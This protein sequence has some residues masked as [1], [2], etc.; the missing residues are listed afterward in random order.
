MLHLSGDY[1]AA[2]TAA[3]ELINVGEK[4][5]LTSEQVEQLENVRHPSLV[6]C[7]LRP[8]VLSTAAN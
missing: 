6:R 4:G 1:A 8:D 3:D 5:G 2:E 7:G